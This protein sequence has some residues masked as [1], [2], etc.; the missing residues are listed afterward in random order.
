M[1]WV[2]DEEGEGYIDTETSEFIPSKKVKFIHTDAWRGYAQ[3]KKAVA[4]SSDTGTWSDSPCPTPKVS[5]ELKKLES[6]LKEAGIDSDEVAMQSSNAFMVKR[7]IVPKD[8][9]KYQ[10]AKRIAKKWLGTHKETRYIHDA[11]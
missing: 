6:A 1:A 2:E 10:K 3:P 8:E 5:E 4:G 11:D 7:W 9:E